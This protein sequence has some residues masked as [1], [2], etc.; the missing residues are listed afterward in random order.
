MKNRFAWTAIALL[1]PAS[2]AF[3][4]GKDA[5]RKPSHL[6]IGAKMPMADVKMPSVDGKRYSI[7]DV[8]GEKGTLVVFSC[9]HCP[10]V[11]MYEKRMARIFN[12][13]RKKGIGVIVINSNDPEAYPE[14]R[15]EVMKERAKKFGF[16]F[17]YV[18]DETSDVARAFGATRTPECFLFDAKGK[19]VYWGAIDDNPRDASKVERHYLEDALRALVEGRKIEKQEAKA[20]GC[21]IKYRKKAEPAAPKTEEGQPE[22]GDV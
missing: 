3:C 9:N 13:W 16:D 7:A 6:P 19:L 12:E 11:K 18:V 5:K 21:T 1:L 22:K 4:E 14:D 20:V 8:A 10:Y 17:P 2:L 15:M